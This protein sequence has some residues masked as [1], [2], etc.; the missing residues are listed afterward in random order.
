MNNA[1]PAYSLKKIIRFVDDELSPAERQEIKAHLDTCDVCRSQV[2]TLTRIHRSFV[3]EADIAADT[4]PSLLE[5]PLTQKPD[6]KSF[7]S[8]L[9]SLWSSLFQKRPALG[10]ASI[11]AV[12]AIGVLFFQPWAGPKGPSATINTIDTTAS[13][14]MILETPENRH[15]ILWYTET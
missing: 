4:T 1:C 15:T 3:F 11:A 6:P 5:K 13:S 14:V 2:D 12:L 7:A 8:W 9:G 10:F